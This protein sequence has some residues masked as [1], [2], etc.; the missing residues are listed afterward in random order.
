MILRV[1]DILVDALS[2]CG[3]T[4]LDEPPT[5]SEIQLALRTANIMLDRWASSR[6]L[7]RA[8][9]PI[10]FTTTAGKNTYT[11][12][13]GHALA[14][15]SMGDGVGVIRPP[16]GIN[17]AFYR[18]SG[19]VDVPIEV[20]SKEFYNAL[21]DKVVTTGPPMYI[22]YDP[23]PAQHQIPTRVGT[24]YLYMTPDQRYNIWMETD[25]YLFEFVSVTDL[26]TFEPAY[27]EAILYGLAVRLFRHFHPSNVQIPADVAAIASSSLNNLRTLNATVIMASNDIPSKASGWYNVFSDTVGR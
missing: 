10:S 26:L 5:P 15:I 4:A 7:L 17:S 11:I 12:G 14:D 27:Y 3:A 13:E 22:A 19:A 23:G 21:G 18:D 1:N 9:T 24:L 6:L 2:L 25:T 16:L 20:V 8:T